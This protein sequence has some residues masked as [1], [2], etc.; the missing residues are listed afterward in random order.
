MGEG[1]IRPNERHNKCESMFG[2]NVMDGIMDVTIITGAVFR[3][4]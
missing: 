2:Y 3:S 4:S 1:K